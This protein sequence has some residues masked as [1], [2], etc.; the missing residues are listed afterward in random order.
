MIAESL[1]LNMEVR[2]TNADGNTV[3]V[4]YFNSAIDKNGFNMNMS[5]NIINK[6]LVA[7]NLDSIK[8]QYIEFNNRVMENALAYGFDFLK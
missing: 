2:I 5:I 7:D 1:N 8:Q 3:P 4:G 6:Q